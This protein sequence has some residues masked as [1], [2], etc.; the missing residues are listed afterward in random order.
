M[1]NKPW[2]DIPI[3]LTGKDIQLIEDMLKN[4]ETCPNNKCESCNESTSFVRT[5]LKKVKRH[6]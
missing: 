3:F 6:E 1:S 2:S 4:I 5:I